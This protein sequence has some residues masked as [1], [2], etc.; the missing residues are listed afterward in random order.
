VKSIGRT[1][2]FNCEFA[3]I[4]REQKGCVLLSIEWNT[5]E[6]SECHQ[7]IFFIVDIEKAPR[8]I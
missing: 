8:H 3:E 4:K 7:N 1:L 2:I 5:L 6:M